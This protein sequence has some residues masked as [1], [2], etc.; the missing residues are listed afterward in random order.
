MGN[1]ARFVRLSDVEPRDLIPNAKARFVHTE[2]MTLAYWD[3][4]LDSELGA[5]S[6]PHEQVSNIIEGTFELTVSGVLYRLEPGTAFV[7]PPHAEHSGRAITK[8]KLI[9][10][11]YPVRED[12]R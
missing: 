10:V 11:F 2:H 1:Q 3:F 8:C 6:H 7:I 9:D 12:Y 5:H 4:E